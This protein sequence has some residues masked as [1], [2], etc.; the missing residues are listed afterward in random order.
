MSKSSRFIRRERQLFDAGAAANF[1]LDA[2]GGK[3]R[4]HLTALW[5]NWRTVMGEAIADLAFPLGHKDATLLIGADD[6]MSMQELSLQSVEILERANAFMDSDF[7]RQ[8][9]VALMQGQRDLSRKRAQAP[10]VPFRVPKPPRLGGLAGKLDPQSPV[11]RSYEAYVA[12]FAS[13]E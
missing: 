2:H 3:E 1:F 11:T 10:Y 13:E 12:M 4:R 6:N 8:V 7:F 9:K 5:Q